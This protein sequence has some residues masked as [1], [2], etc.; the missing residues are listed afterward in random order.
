MFNKVFSCQVKSGQFVFIAQL[1]FIVVLLSFVV[2]CG[3][4]SGSSAADSNG[5]VT[6][7]S[8]SAAVKSCVTA[9][10]SSG[11]VSD[12]N[13]ARADI[14]DGGLAYDKWWVAITGAQEP[15]GDHPLWSTQSTNTRTGSTTWRCK[16]C[17]GWDYKGKDGAYNSASSHFTGFIGV[18][19]AKVNSVTEVFCA[20]K[21]LEN[22]TFGGDSGVMTDLSILD[23]A[24]F[25]VD[26]GGKGRGII[27]YGVLLRG[28]N[29]SIG[30]G[31]I[32]GAGNQDFDKSTSNGGGGCGAAGSCHGSDGTQNAG[33][34]FS[35]GDVALDNPWEFLHKVRY[36]QPG[37]IMPSG[38]DGKLTLQQMSNILAYAQ[39]QLPQQNPGGGSAIEGDFIRGGLLYDNWPA[40]LT[41]ESSTPPLLPATTMPLFE[42]RADTVGNTRSGLGTWR[43][44]ECH[45]W[46]YKGKDGVYGNAAS[47]HYTNFMGVLNAR[48]DPGAT[49]SFLLNFLKNGY[50]A[51]GVTYHRFM[52]Y[53][54]DADLIQLVS[55]I[56]E[57]VI[58]T[59]R[60]ISTTPVGAGKGDLAN[61]EF[62]YIFSRTDAS[63]TVGCSLCH[64][65]NGMGIDFGVNEFLK[66]LALGNPWEVLHKIRFG[67]PHSIGIVNQEMPSALRSGFTNVD[68]ADILTYS[69]NL[70]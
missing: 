58:E 9:T 26:A 4:D 49:E 7:T 5:A 29:T 2:A 10:T 12:E 48:N 30:D 23:I 20:I 8:S 38:I 39:L 19:D 28:D 70:P 55:F 16:E 53:M 66:D 59:D 33:N 25:I 18:M 68:A 6:T 24:A 60:Y 43:C 42:L 51:N 44:K 21:S 56:K 69:Q 27:D 61:G 63:S 41:A 65:L 31:S 52:P 1:L 11:F 35:I 67:E 47:S 57:G 15:Q 37:S 22:H 50:T 54:T 45:G 17:H 62:L 32:G 14:R 3:S 40:V 13:L 46:D 34:E 64:G 36:G